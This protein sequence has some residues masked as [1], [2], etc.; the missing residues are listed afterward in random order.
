MFRQVAGYWGALQKMGAV[1][2]LRLCPTEPGPR[3]CC[4]LTHLASARVTVYSNQSTLGMRLVSRIRK[5]SEIGLRRQTPR[6]PGPHQGMSLASSPSVPG[7][8]NAPAS[9]CSESLCPSYDPRCVT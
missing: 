5:N 9:H 4:S 2:A 1:V 7:A 8:G 6:N 3:D